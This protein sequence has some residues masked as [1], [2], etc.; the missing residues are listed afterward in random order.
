MSS[1][2]SA[3]VAARASS[4]IIGPHGLIHSLRGSFDSDA[5]RPMLAPKSR[6]DCQT[7]ASRR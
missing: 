6:S 2:A 7:S 5:A 4:T 1:P 3:P